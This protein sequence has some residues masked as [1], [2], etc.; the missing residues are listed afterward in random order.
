[1]TA[2]AQSRANGLRHM[3]W[4]LQPRLPERIVRAASSIH[5]RGRSESS[6][7]RRRGGRLLPAFSGS[8]SQGGSYDRTAA[9]PLRREQRARARAA[10]VPRLGACRP[11]ARDRAAA[12]TAEIA[13]HSD[14]YYLFT[15]LTLIGTALFVPVLLELM[16]LARSRAPFPAIV[17]A[18]LMQVGTLVG[19]ADAGI[20][21]VYWQTGARG[22]DPAQM[23]ALLDRVENAAGVSI[24]FMVGGFSLIAGSLLLGIALWRTRVAP[25]W[26][27]LCLPLGVIS[28][29]FAFAAGSRPL[30]A[31]QLTRPPRRPH[32]RGGAA[33][34]GRD[35]RH[36]GSRDRR[37]VIAAAPPPTQRKTRSWSATS[38]RGSTGP[39]PATHDRCA[40]AD[41]SPPTIGRRSP[42][43]YHP[44]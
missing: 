18:G 22:A 40:G 6:P 30:L 16:R 27:A 9:P 34:A 31:G 33:S 3:P 28:N 23:T 17:G 19:V 10:P 42:R 37:A 12:Q 13:R 32:R 20:Q 2:I 1:M 29:I 38:V 24:V 44:V 11:L 15:L 25:A 43:G 7:G 39:T 36:H 4:K 26:A 35:A 14:R 41:H 21:L 8:A 5:P